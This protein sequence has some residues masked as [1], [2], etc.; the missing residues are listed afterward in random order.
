MKLP[1]SLTYEAGTSGKRKVRSYVKVTLFVVAALVIFL[2][3]AL[4]QQSQEI[5]DMSAT[6]TISLA[7]T[8]TRTPAPT[9]VSEACPSNPSDWTLVD[10]LD[11]DVKKV[12]DPPCVYD[13]LAHAVAWALAIQEGY[14]RQDAA[15][16]L[17]YTDFPMAQMT[18]VNVADNE[19]GHKAIKVSFVP[20]VP[21]FTE[22]YFN[23]K[24]NPAVAI[25]IR[26]CFRTF[27]IVGNLKQEWEKGYPLIC[28]VSMD[29]EASNMIMCLDNRCYASPYNP[30]RF[31]ALYGYS[32]E[33]AWIWLGNEKDKTVSGIKAEEV[34]ADRNDLMLS[35]RQAAA[36]D[37]DWLAKNFLLAA[38]PLPAHW[39]SLTSQDDLQAIV[40][41]LNAQMSGGGN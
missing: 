12:I 41:S 29:V 2:A 32:D 30:T 17:G 22:W 20:P 5:R 26:G 38:E 4:Y 24:G 1:S 10:F 36:W 34:Q 25:A 40:N 14:S 37:A 8:L 19:Q 31:Y 21:N 13:G 6:R 39:Q 3:L 33:H 7:P 9:A 15:T 28:E 27:T 16:A 23:G 11:N 18:E 35:H